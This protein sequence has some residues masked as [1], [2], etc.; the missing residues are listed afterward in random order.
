MTNNPKKH[1]RVKQHTR[2]EL[3]DGTYVPGVTTICG[4]LAKPALVPWANKLGLEGINVGKFTD[5]LADIGSVAHDVIQAK[6]T[7]KAADL[8]DYTAK[9]IECAKP[10]I[11]KFENW[12]KEN[13]VK[14]ILVETPLVS[15][16]YKYGG[17]LDLYADINGKKT[18]LDWKTGSRFYREH[19]IQLS[20][21]MNLLMENEHPVEQCMLVGIGRDDKED[22]HQNVVG[23]MNIR[24]KQFRHLL[25]IYQLS[26]EIGDI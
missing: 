12:F 6:L 16:K 3:K 21:N 5:E 10:C 15:E 1:K 17:T 23:G 13:K 4:Q 20:A 7:N 11:T 2:Y 24:F 26:K 22:F 25:A 14:P 8:S 18:L 19:K 9:Q